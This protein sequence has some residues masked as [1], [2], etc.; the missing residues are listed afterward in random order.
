LCCESV[1]ID[2]APDHFNLVPDH[3]HLEPWDKFVEDKR[4]AANKR[5]IAFKKPTM[6]AYQSYLLN[7]LD[8]FTAD[9]WS[10]EF[11]KHFSNH[12]LL[13]IVQPFDGNIIELNLD[14]LDQQV[15]QSNAAIVITKYSQFVQRSAKQAQADKQDD[16]YNQV[17]TSVLAFIS[18]TIQPSK[19]RDPKSGES[20]AN[21]TLQKVNNGKVERR[22]WDPDSDEFDL[23]TDFFLLISQESYI[24]YLLDI[25]LVGESSNVE[26]AILATLHPEHRPESKRNLL[27]HTTSVTGIIASLCSAPTL[28]N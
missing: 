23:H 15:K 6:N 22:V 13:T 26:E 16:Y 24:P 5:G 11:F 28:H 17:K 10:D 12:K 3:F 7:T 2:S 21:I 1:L 9:N 4:A 25:D 27:N 20:H 18:K 19:L 14:K 8:V